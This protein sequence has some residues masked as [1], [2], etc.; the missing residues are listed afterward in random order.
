MVL[1]T[2]EREAADRA[3]WERI[4]AAACALLGLLLLALCAAVTGPVAGAIADERA[5]LDA[6]PCGPAEE[7]ARPADDCLR[8]I[9]G[10][11]R[12]A[13]EATS[14]RNVAV[15]RVRLQPPVPAPADHSIDLDSNGDLAHAIE[16]GDEVEVVTWRDVRVSV[17]RDGVTERLHG[18]PDEA[19][20][21]VGLTLIGVWL[22]LI[23]FLAA[24][25]SARRAR[26]LAAGR[27]V[28]AR[29]RF[30]PAKWIAVA[31]VPL[32]VSFGCLS[33]WDAWTAAAMT[34]GL[35]ALIALPATYAALRWDTPSA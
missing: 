35:W 31:V 13:G 2:G 27:P 21:F 14:G 34:V 32:V 20:M 28:T 16:P 30:G 6:R 9:R 11:V 26:G 22:S 29:V 19:G 4:R 7:A 8:T 3:R 17:S 18:L 12:T 23:A 24:Y 25:G 1:D 33:L 15:F 10:T 5:F